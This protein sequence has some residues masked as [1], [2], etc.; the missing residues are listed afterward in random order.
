LAKKATSAVRAGRRSEKRKMRNRAVKTATKT[1]LDQAR[2]SL[3]GQD[4]AAAEGAV[5]AAVRALD[6]AVHKGTVHCHSAA[7][8]KSRLMKRLNAL[9]AGASPAKA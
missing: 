8:R 7:R 6:K 1:Y 5:L 4:A 9:R 2:A 3:R